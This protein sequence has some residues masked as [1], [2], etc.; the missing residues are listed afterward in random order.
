LVEQNTQ[1]KREAALQDRKLAA[2]KEHIETLEARLKETQEKQV[3]EAE[4]F[5]TELQAI[6]GLLEKARDRK[7]PGSFF[8]FA[9]GGE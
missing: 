2:K 3:T 6:R 4:R 5:N 8:G 1:L 9:R 7:K